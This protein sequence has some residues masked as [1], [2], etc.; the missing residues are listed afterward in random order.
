MAISEIPWK[1]AISVTLPSQSGCL[2]NSELAIVWS[3]Q[4]LLRGLGAL[5]MSFIRACFTFS[6]QSQEYIF[7]R[8]ARQ[9]G[10]SASRVN[11]KQGA[12]RLLAT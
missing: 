5:A 10:H 11:G 3:F 7:V 4:S 1:T 2:V 12:I 9:I 6:A 8:A